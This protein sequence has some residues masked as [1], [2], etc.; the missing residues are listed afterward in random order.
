[1]MMRV[2]AHQVMAENI[3]HLITSG[4]NVNVFV[5]GRDQ[6]IGAITNTT[7][8]EFAKEVNNNLGLPPARSPLLPQ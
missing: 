7:V 2:G 3:T 4:Q 6:A 1:M 8:D 5:T